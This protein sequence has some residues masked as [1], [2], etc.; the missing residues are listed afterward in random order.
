M[1]PFREG[2]SPRYLQLRNICSI[3]SGTASTSLSEPRKDRIS[4]ALLQCYSPLPG[5]DPLFSLPYSQPSFSPS[6]FI[7]PHLRPL[8][9]DLP[10]PVSPRPLANG[11]S[12]S[13]LVLLTRCTEWHVVFRNSSQGPCASRTVVLSVQGSHTIGPYGCNPILTVCT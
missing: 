7:D 4:V 11:C 12:Y 6:C 2:N 10:V 8:P 5:L 13:Q 3:A 1:F 9:T